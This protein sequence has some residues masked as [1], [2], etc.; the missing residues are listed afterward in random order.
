MVVI[1]GSNLTKSYGKINA[2]HNLSFAIEENK[3]TGLIGRNGAGKTTLLKLIAG[4]LRP[5]GGEIKV[6]GQNPFNSLTVSANMIFV[7]DNIIPA[8]ILGLARVNSEYFRTLYGF[9]ASENSLPLFALKII[10]ASI[11]LFGLSVL[12]SNRLEVK[13]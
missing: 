2:I 1:E 12:L 9:F 6:Y 13:E 10:M 8:V 11:V 5:T 7:D 4:Y 3:I